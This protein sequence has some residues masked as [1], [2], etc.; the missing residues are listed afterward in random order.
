MVSGRIHLPQLPSLSLSFCF[1]SLSNSIPSSLP[2]LFLPLYI[3]ISLSICSSLPLCFSFISFLES[4]FPLPS[5]PIP[6]S[7]LATSTPCSL[8]PSPPLLI[9][10]SLLSTLPQQWQRS[11]V[12]FRSDHRVHCDDVIRCS[13]WIKHSAQYFSLCIHDIHT[14]NIRCTHLLNNFQGDWGRDGSK[15]G[16]AEFVFLRRL[17]P[18]P[19]LLLLA[20]LGCCCC[21][22]PGPEHLR[23]RRWRMRG[24]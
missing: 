13:T 19:S 15:G 23:G 14:I 4:S 10:L 6:P 1:P 3:T 7:C 2:P 18:D 17:A 5:P 24:G 16:G 20:F 9:L 11:T 8:L 21:V 12:L 22:R